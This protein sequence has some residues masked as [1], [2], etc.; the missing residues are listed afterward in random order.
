[1]RLQRKQCKLLFEGKLF[2]SGPAKTKT[3]KQQEC[4][5]VITLKMTNRRKS[6]ILWKQ[7]CDF[8]LG[9]FSTH[10]RKRSIFSSIFFSVAAS[11]HCTCS[12]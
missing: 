10:A 7:T 12:P 2:V 8:L 5:R 4:I 6:M 9:C 1:M 3:N 11:P